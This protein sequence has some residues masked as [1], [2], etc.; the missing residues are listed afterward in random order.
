MGIRLVTVA[1]L[2][3]CC[4][5]VLAKSNNNEGDYSILSGAGQATQSI[6]IDDLLED[7][8]ILST[9]EVI[10][11]NQQQITPQ[12]ELAATNTV[13]V[14]TP[15]N[16]LLGFVNDDNSL[17]RTTNGSIVESCNNNTCSQGN[18]LAY[19]ESSNG[20]VTPVELTPAQTGALLGIHAAASGSTDDEIIN[21]FSNAD[22]ATRIQ[23]AAIAESTL[24]QGG[25][26]LV[27][28]AAV[29][30]RIE[31]GYGES[32]Y[33]FGGSDAD[34]AYRSALGSD[35]LDA[36]VS[37][38]QDLLD[39]IAL[40]YMGAG[41]GQD[42]A[43]QRAREYVDQVYD[44]PMLAGGSPLGMPIGSTNEF[45][46]NEYA[47]ML[48]T[49]WA[50]LNTT[51]E[52]GG[53]SD[54]PANAHASADPVLFEQL[55]NPPSE[56]ELA[57]SLSGSVGM[58]DGLGTIPTGI[59][60]GPGTINVTL[61]GST[62]TTIPTDTQPIENAYSWLDD[63][64][65]HSSDIIYV[66]LKR[67]LGGP[68][69]TVYDSLITADG[70]IRISQGGLVQSDAP[71]TATTFMVTSLLFF[72]MMLTALMIFYIFVYGGYKTAQQGELFGKEWN[73]FWVPARSIGSASMIIPIEAVAG[74]SGAQV[75]V[76]MVILLGTAFA[77]TLAYYSFRYL[78][79][80]PVIEPSI[81]SNDQFVASV[82]K[83]RAC[84]KV[85]SEMGLPVLEDPT[86]YYFDG[87]GQVQ[88]DRAFTPPPVEEDSGLFSVILGFFS[89]S[90][91]G[92]R[93]PLHFSDT[94]LK[95]RHRY[96]A[97][98]YKETGYNPII[99]GITRYQYGEFGECGSVFVPTLPRSADYDIHDDVAKMIYG[100][101]RGR[102]RIMLNNEDVDESNNL[103]TLLQSA[104]SSDADFNTIFDGVATNGK[105]WINSMRAAR[106]ASVRDAY[107]RLD[108]DVKTALN[109]FYLSQNLGDFD[110]DDENAQ[111]PTQQIGVLAA[112]LTAAQEDFYQILSSGLQNSMTSIADPST[113]IMNNAI[114]QLGWPAIGTFYWLI[115]H[116]QSELMKLFD[117]SDLTAGSP[118][119]VQ[120]G[121]EEINKRLK[122]EIER[123]NKII[124]KSIGP[125]GIKLVANTIA[126]A[127]QGVT[128]D[129]GSLG[130]SLSGM[131]SSVFLE[132]G[133][134][135]DINNLNVSPIER[136]RHLGVVLTN[137]Y[138]AAVFSLG[139]IS[140][141]SDATGEA[142][143]SA[144]P[145][146]VYGVFVGKLIKGL[147]DS[148]LVML[149]EVASPLV[150]GAFICANII[151][152]L[153][154]IMLMAS[155]FGYLVYCLESLVG[156]NFWFVNHGNPE[157]HEVFGKGGDGYPI[158]MTLFLRPTL[159]VI[160]FVMGIS[161]NWVFGH[162][163]NVTIL[164][165]TNIQ[166][167]EPGGIGLGN[168]SQ[169]AGVILVYSGMQLFASY[170][171]FSLTHE[172][173]NAILRWMG[174]SDH[175]DLGEREGKDLALAI[176]TQA[177][178]AMGTRLGS[179]A[180]KKEKGEPEEES[181]VSLTESKG[182]AHNN[183]NQGTPDPNAGKL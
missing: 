64:R 98:I 3:L 82:A 114:R 119:S 16:P 50:T 117:F 110:T 69:E 37:S 40:D 157:G 164:P 6:T 142:S 137:S 128:A 145:F 95:E 113:A 160:G 85:H 36:M 162:L 78:T 77:S 174:V 80:M 86:I 15:V 168:L 66:S 11:P 25:A 70:S 175:Q 173:P 23:A 83:A 136:V 4:C 49:D 43:Y 108:T 149:Q 116:R 101:L 33:Q 68:I 7:D 76:I 57:N 121:S 166:N 24:E 181:P 127:E 1:Y 167:M 32:S 171:S 125:S 143:K 13:S 22:E 126:S 48:A 129:A 42:E 87:S 73:T 172:L 151:P 139:T 152:A 161:M 59:I 176:G 56:S 2:S 67:L 60:S 111:I 107:T 97:N 133:W 140:A 41:M 21:F 61:P 38:R 63:I 105:L 103:S 115:E 53:Y 138:Y 54:I 104:E 122:N 9:G 84:L 51:L 163:I 45:T 91:S 55:S 146:G 148:L 180:T 154:Y 165:A 141:F 65:L 27:S 100:Q 89:S 35:N 75:L 118:S 29:K 120:R 8:A 156:V 90:G 99:F 169:F 183:S 17:V 131:V 150:T 112:N 81:I 170:K 135:A 109:N 20:Q 74:M 46:A 5:A 10:E 144:G 58:A 12:T 44:Q 39:Q 153:P 26:D 18:Y 92:S 79:S 123:I 72:V 14:V 130:S 34:A 155:V 88:A 31:D 179:S 30:E 71:S 158:L 124:D 96:I 93:D 182:S 178:S 134:F 106:F 159:I 28:A 19:I 94:S 47:A 102:G 147:A 52:L 62:G 177:G 132:G